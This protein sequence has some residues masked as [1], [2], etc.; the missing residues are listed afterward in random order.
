MSWPSFWDVAYRHGDHRD[1]W[2]PMAPPVELLALLAADVIGPGH[3]VLDLGCGSGVES[4][5]LARHGCRVVG[6][7]ASMPALTL[8]R[9]PG[10]ATT[11]TVAWIRSDARCLPVAAA[12]VDAVVDRGCLHVIARRARGTYADEVTRVLRPGGVV[13]LRGAAHD[14]DDAGI[15]GMDEAELD[16]L[17]PP[18]VFTRGPLVANDLHARAETLPGYL[19]MLRK[20]GPAGQHR[21]TRTE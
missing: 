11:G 8:A 3:T 9:R 5:V 20:R 21:G 12:V 18:S 14:D 2:E 4:R 19:A 10:S 7:D 13:L 17:F 1:H 6:L 16:R 15:V